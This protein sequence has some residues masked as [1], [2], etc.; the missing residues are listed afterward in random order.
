MMTA[1]RTAGTSGPQQARSTRRAAQALA[2]AQAQPH[3]P[4]RTALPASAMPYFAAELAQTAAHGAHLLGAAETPSALCL[5]STG[6]ELAPALPAV[7]FWVSKTAAQA[8]DCS[9]VSATATA[10]EG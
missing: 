7:Q 8:G 3:A 4:A 10:F 5:L 2:Q 9:A 6:P 1:I